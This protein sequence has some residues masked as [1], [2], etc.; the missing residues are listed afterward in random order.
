MTDIE[1][2]LDKYF[3]AELDNAKETSVVIN[4]TGNFT[5]EVFW[6]TDGKHTVH[7][8]AETKEGRAAALKWGDMAYERL[9]LKYGTKQAQAVKEYTKKE[10]IKESCQHPSEKVVVM[11]SKSPKNPGKKFRKCEVCN[12]FLGWAN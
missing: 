2:E 3:E 9:V 11:V 8:I 10:D 7:V 5:G 4:E 12:S 6:S 1:K